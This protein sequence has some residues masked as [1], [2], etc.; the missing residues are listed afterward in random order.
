MKLRNRPASE[1]FL[2]LPARMA[3]R[4]AP[5]FERFEPEV[6]KQKQLRSSSALICSFARARVLLLQSSGQVEECT[7]EGRAVRAIE[8]P[9]GVLQG[10]GQVA[11][12]G[13]AFE[14]CL[15]WTFG[16]IPVNE[17]LMSL[18]AHRREWIPAE[19]RLDPPD[20]GTEG[21]RLELPD[22][23]YYFGGRPSYDS[24][25]PTAR[26][27]RYDRRDRRWTHVK[28][29]PSAVEN[30][31]AVAGS[32]RIYVVGGFAWQTMRPEAWGHQ[33]A[34]TT[35]AHEY[36]PGADNWRQVPHAALSHIENDCV[37]VLEDRLTIYQPI[38]GALHQ[39]DHQRGTWT[40]QEEAWPPGARAVLIS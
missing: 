15:R 35:A 33:L 37:C 12:C 4:E 39:Y 10:Y 23:V 8:P 36:D 29:M 31:K 22:C 28:P 6:R 18:A 2:F 17:G 14:L 38:D 13:T 19:L 30:A 27:L 34:L 25:R 26:S 24:S 20:P 3:D 16:P 11:P 1:E 21:A 7:Q 32:S 9:E 5:W 40:A